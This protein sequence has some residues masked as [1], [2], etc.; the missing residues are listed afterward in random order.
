MLSKADNTR[1]FI[2]EKAAPIFNTKGY[3]ATSMNDILK[4]TGLAKG[5]I[6]G[7]FKS[8]DEIAVEAFEYA[9]NQL[10][11]ALI[12]KIK[13]L[14]T[15][16]G[17]LLAILQFYKNYTIV[18]HIAGGC[19]LL[20]TAIDADDNIPFL[21]QKAAFALREMLG[22]LE[23]IIQKGINNGEF[24]NDLNAGKEAAIFFSIIEGGIMMSKVSD[25]PKILNDLLENL[26]EQIMKRYIC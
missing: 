23:F 8:K 9:Y 16:S 19:P 6:Y 7:N 13:P 26:K 25:N 17:Q 4:A 24:R 11:A 2:I 14:P 3:A 1:Q 12:Q 22:S 15:A 10:K 5:G 21:K 20:N 18:P